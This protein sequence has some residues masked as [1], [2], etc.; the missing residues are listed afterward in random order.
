MTQER[1][2]ILLVD[3]DEDLLE[4]VRAVVEKEYTTDVA[5]SGDEAIKKVAA[6]RYDVIV[7]DVMMQGLGDGLDAAKKLK[8]DSRTKDI[9]II[10][11]TSVHKHYDYRSQID[12]NFFPN[13]KWLDKPADP[14][15]LM[16]E[17]KKLIP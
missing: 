4:Q 5:S 2:S 1:K 10:M 13:D 8:E 11:L 6:K 7:M 16:Q 9:P 14:K 12:E 17:I 15:V 3:D